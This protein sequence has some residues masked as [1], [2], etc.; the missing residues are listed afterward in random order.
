MNTSRQRAYL[1]SP[2]GFAASTQAFMAELV[3]ALGEVVDVENPWDLGGPE[4]GAAFDRAN[5]L[6]G[7][8]ERVAALHAIDMG[9]GAQNEAA[10]RRSDI[11]VA[12]RDGVYVESRT[13]SEIGFAYGLG[14]RSYGLRTDL[15]LAG[16]NLGAT[17]NLQVQY[18]IEASGGAVFEQAGDLL[19]ALRAG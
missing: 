6:P 9:I 10:I 3:R 4:L 5:R 14:K 16:D 7:Y 12:V 19:A 15:R 2:L 13:A 1:A 8:A 18:W 11:V 17:V